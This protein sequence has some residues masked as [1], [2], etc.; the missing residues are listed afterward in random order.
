MPMLVRDS[1]IKADWRPVAIASPL[2]WSIHQ[3]YGSVPRGR[4]VQP[5]NGIGIWFGVD[6]PCGA[7][8]RLDGRLLPMVE[9][10]G[11]GIWVICQGYE[12]GIPTV[13]HWAPLL[14]EELEH[15]E[16]IAS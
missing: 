10:A 16:A 2:P 15:Y 11:G 8:H 7:D 9:R 13:T 12:F 4:G 1:Q 5:W 14:P 3:L 6:Q